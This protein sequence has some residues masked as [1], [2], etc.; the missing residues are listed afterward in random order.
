M[1]KKGSGE[2]NSGS[3]KKQEGKTVSKQAISGKSPLIKGKDTIAFSPSGGEKE[4]LVV[5]RKADFD[6]KISSK[7]MLITIGA[8]FLVFIILL[9]FIAVIYFYFN[10]KGRSLEKTNNLQEALIT[11]NELCHVKLS[12]TVNLSKVKAVTLVFS[13]SQ[14]NKYNY[15]AAA[16]QEYDINASQLGLENLSD[17]TQISAEITYKSASS[18]STIAPIPSTNRTNQTTGTT[19]RTGSTGGTSGGSSGG[20]GDTCTATRTCTYYYD[21]SQCGENL[22]NGCKSILDCNSCPG[23][24]ICSDGDCIVPPSCT[25]NANCTSLT[26]A[27]GIGKCNS[28]G[29]CYTS[30]NA[31]TTICKSN[32]SECDAVDYCSGSSKSCVDNNK[33]DGTACSAG[34]CQNGK[35]AASCIND[36]GCSSI[37]IFCNG[38]SFY[39]CTKG[40]DGCLDKS[41]SVSC[42]VGYQCSNGT[43]CIAFNGCTS[44]ENCTSLNGVCAVGRCNSTSG[45][46]YMS[47]N[48]S[49][50]VCRASTGECDAVDYCS[51]GSL[52]CVDNNKTDGTACSEGTC[53]GGRCIQAETSCGNN[54]IEAGEVCDGTSLNGQTCIS[55]GYKEGNI[56]CCSNC[57]K[58]D[59]SQCRNI[60]RSCIDYDGLNYS[61]SSSVSTSSYGCNG[62]GCGT[63]GSDGSS[64]PVCWGGGGSAS[65][66]LCN[67]TTGMLNERIC[68]AD[69]TTGNIQYDCAQEGKICEGGR[70]VASI[71]TPSRTC[72][73]Y[74]NLNQ[75]GAGLSDGCSNIL[76]CNSCTNGKACVSGSCVFGCTS[77]ENC[78]YLNGA[79]ASGKCNSTGACYISYSSSSTICRDRISECDSVEYCSG[80]SISCPIDSNKTNGNVC[81][82]GICQNG[83][84]IASCVNECD[85][86]GSFCDGNTVYNC[87]RGEDSCLKIVNMHTCPSS[88]PYC[89]NGAC[90]SFNCGDQHCSKSTGENCSNCEEDCGACAEQGSVASLSFIETIWDWIKDIFS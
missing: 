12:D 70:C 45:I 35:C 1:K 24:K 89:L 38:N 90:V 59:L 17:I 73:Y 25:T 40:S 2:L 76:D 79:C 20:S 81:N 46:C 64:S 32:V 60:T 54:T 56:S 58:F 15:S 63:D 83:M 65:L 68:N 31:S 47:Y 48:S 55:Q 19:G 5:D 86:E 71:C 10:D 61:K 44:D 49:T 85:L 29:T 18:S 30:Y 50:T 37:G 34:T 66:D 77:D 8:V 62:P 41:A 16:S 43:G 57:S 26:G 14:G 22:Y 78:S 28:S 51:S 88:D 21:K 3:V 9:S 80:S 74:Y 6:K 42:A 72:S 67:S 4:K 13:D 84:C 52:S 82:G 27:C 33:T 36:T 87:S 39:N 23:S 75:C 69:N 11:D 53:Q 7:T